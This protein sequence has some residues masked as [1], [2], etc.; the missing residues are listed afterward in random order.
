MAVTTG[1]ILT[2]NIIEMIVPVGIVGI[3]AVMIIPMPTLLLDL[4]LS[5]SITL[6]I[7]I[8]LI[9]AHMVKPLD[10]AVFPS[11]LLITTLF[12]LSLNVASTRII[13]LHGNEGVS[14]AGQVI[15]AFGVFVVGG[16]Y[17]VGMVV[18]IILVIINFVVIT[19]GAGRIAEVSARFTLDAMPGKQMAIDADLNS[20]LIGEDEARKRR[21]DVTREADFYG[22][23]DGASKFVRGDAIAGILITFINIIGGII[24][25]VFQQGMNIVDAMSIYTILTI[26]DGLVAQIPALVISTAAGI[27]VTRAAS[28]SDMGSEFAS[29]ILSYPK[30]IAGAAGVLFVLG[31][32]PG[33]PH[34]AFLTLA[35]VTGGIAYMSNQGM[36]AAP[37]KEEVKEV[38]KTPEKDEIILPDPLTIEV[39]YRLIPLVDSESGGE[40]LDRIKA[41]RRQIAA[42]IGF[43][44][45]PIHI[46]DNLQL[47]P[48]E[49]IILLRGIEVGRGSVMMNYQMA[50]DPGTAQKGLEGIP[51]KEPAFGLPALWIDEGLKDKA[52]IMGWTVVNPAVAIITHIAEVVKAN[53]YRL[54]TRQDVQTILDALARTHPKIVE[55]LVPAQLSLGGVEKVLQNLLREKIPIRDVL[56]IAETLADYAPSTKD[57][58]ILTEYVRQAMS[59]TITRQYTTEDG[60]LPI[61][62]LDPRLEETISKSIHQ[63]QYG[64]NIAIEP[65]IAHKLMNKVSEGAQEMVNQGYRPLVMTSSDVRRFVRKLIERT[66]PLVAVVGSNEVSGD[67]RIKNI[68]VVSL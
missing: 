6:S 5:M 61:M 42:E 9:S 18:F 34:L 52:K 63:S 17:A 62:L 15:K 39:G 58:D 47:K 46:K 7:I 1:K 23:M 41:M 32:I 10:F 22:A 50:I 48:E 66:L 28:E 67:I 26:G 51:A 57:T 13:L 3:L 24:I 65:S 33:L 2:K 11:I 16:N 64:I 45:P 60:L 37:K 4:L 21:K 20:G 49:Y 12:R 30:A 31:L 54:L 40:L 56:S 44:V 43:L 27:T 29:Q 53:A 55:E 35:G 14:A 59:G 19:K 38:P 25:G 36:F 8:L 68:K